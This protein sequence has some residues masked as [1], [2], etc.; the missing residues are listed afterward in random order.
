MAQHGT[1]EIVCKT[2]YQRY[3][4]STWRATGFEGRWRDHQGRLRSGKHRNRPLQAAW[5]LYGESDFYFR[6]LDVLPAD[7]ELCLAQEQFYFDRCTPSVLF[8]VRLTAAG[9]SLGIRS[10]PYKHA[11]PMSQ[12]QKDKIRSTMKGVKKSP[13]HIAAVREGMRRAAA[14]REAARLDARSAASDPQQTLPT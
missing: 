3:I 7:K 4:G 8:N 9:K 1:Y 11:V 12:Q 2:T 6:I 13:Q 5:N 14:A 10:R